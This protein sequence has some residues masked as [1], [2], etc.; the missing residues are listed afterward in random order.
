[1]TAATCAFATRPIETTRVHH[2]DWRRGGR[3]AARGTGAAAFSGRS[4]APAH[5]ADGKSR[6]VVR[7]AAVRG[8]LTVLA[9][10]VAEDEVGP[11]H[12]VAPRDKGGQRWTIGTYSV[13]WGFP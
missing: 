7:M 10:N 6:P 2:A 3:V 9:F 12:G 5:G 11:S 4:F 13:S 1:M 8:A